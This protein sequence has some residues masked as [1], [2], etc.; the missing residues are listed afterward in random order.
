[1]PFGRVY[2]SADNRSILMLPAWQRYI[3]KI[4]SIHASSSG[5]KPTIDEALE[6]T[7]TQQEELEHYDFLLTDAKAELVDLKGQVSKASESKAFLNGTLSD[8]EKA[9]QT[10]TDELA[11]LEASQTESARTEMTLQRQVDV[12]QLHVKELE[13]NL[14]IVKKSEKDAKGEANNARLKLVEGTKQI[15]GLQEIARQC[16]AAE[17]ELLNKIETSNEAK[18]IAL[19]ELEAYA[20]E[21]EL[22]KQE[23]NQEIEMHIATSESRA[24]QIDALKDDTAAEL[25][26]LTMQVENNVVD[27]RQARADKELAVKEKAEVEQDMQVVLS[28]LKE[29]LAASNSDLEGAAMAGDIDASYC[30]LL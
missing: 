16:A 17:D 22:E 23:L 10:Q 27:L 21:A 8:Y 18:E 30:M 12:S 19:A 28:G 4:R 1:M 29:Q 3:D 20:E 24:L 7:S 11:R 14:E 15:K 6:L 5:V 25:E 2:F 26:Q 9:Y 13:K